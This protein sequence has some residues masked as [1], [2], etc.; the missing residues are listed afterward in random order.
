MANKICKQC[1]QRKDELQ[2]G[3][4]G[5]KGG[6]S[7]NRA[8]RWIKTIICIDCARGLVET[9]TPGHRTNDRWDLTD[10]KWFIKD[11]EAREAKAAQRAREI[12]DAQ[13]HQ[14]R[15]REEA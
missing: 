11:H 8:P 9:A 2:C 10:L 1:G 4:A 7:Y 14:R 12:L 3:L 15:M 6:G 5:R 13:E